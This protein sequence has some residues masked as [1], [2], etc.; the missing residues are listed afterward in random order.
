MVWDGIGSYLVTAAAAVL[1]DSVK[2]KV[3]PVL[4]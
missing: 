2:G 4:N 1:P 3:V